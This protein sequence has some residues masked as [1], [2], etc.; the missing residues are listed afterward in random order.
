MPYGSQ[1][2]ETAQD[3]SVPVKLGWIQGD[4]VTR[5][6]PYDL[7]RLRRRV[8]SNYYTAPHPVVPVPFLDLLDVESIIW[9]VR[10]FYG[11]WLLASR[12]SPERSPHNSSS[13]KLPIRPVTPFRFV[14][15]TCY[16]QLRPS[17]PAMNASILSSR[18]LISY[19]QLGRLPHVG[20]AV[21][22]GRITGPRR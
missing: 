8:I 3:S 16:W 9:L 6:S 4:Y 2:E 21:Y 10:P 22:P 17:S 15:C 7:A 14:S 20:Y 11:A 12:A 5:H 13:E 18:A 1:G 19:S